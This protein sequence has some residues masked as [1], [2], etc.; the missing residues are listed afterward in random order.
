MKIAKSTLIPLI[1]GIVVVATASLYLVKSLVD[2][3]AKSSTK[4]L[5]SDGRQLLEEQQ[6]KEAQAKL[7]QCYQKAQ[8]AEL[9]NQALLL[10][11]RCFSAQD[12]AE[13]AIA[14][15]NK[16]A[17]S[18]AMQSHHAE[19]YYS[20][21]LL[22]PEGTSPAGKPGR[23][24]YFEKAAAT[25][26]ASRHADLAQIEL[27]KM[28]MD[29]GNLRGAQQILKP[30]HD[31]KKNYPQLTQARYKLNMKLLFSPTITEVPESRYYV[32][33][34][35]DTLDGIAKELGTTAALLQ[36]SNG[37]SDPRKLQIGQRLKAV[38]GKFR[39]EISK[40]T[41]V[42]RLMSGDSVLNEYPIGTGKFGKTPVGKFTVGKKIVEPPWFPGD[43]R[44]IPYGDPENVLGTRWMGL[45]DIEQDKELVTQGIGIHGT[46]D[47]SSI[48][49]E[50]SEGCIRMLN[51]DVEELY[52]IIPEATEVI[53]KD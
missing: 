49:K 28:A 21:G 7:E 4:N 19:A 29:R 39:L 26:P 36:R 12:N 44:V 46:S 10:L 6:Y 42:L 38:T 50:S 47:E 17:E 43:G 40:S 33:K 16:V 14:H 48:G 2:L 20:L 22:H 23:K 5:L 35:G 13:Q 8:D 9:K 11:S 30:L 24:E 18:P 37:I 1:V 3:P 53:V 45:E 15:W 41:R 31:N 34:E 27:A 32:V 52:D 51:R 25:Q